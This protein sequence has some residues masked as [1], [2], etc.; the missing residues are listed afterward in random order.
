MLLVK[1]LKA[2]PSDSLGKQLLLKRPLRWDGRYRK[3]AGTECWLGSFVQKSPACRYS[4][5]DLGRGRNI[6]FGLPER[7]RKGF[8]SGL[9][10]VIDSYGTEEPPKRPKPVWSGGCVPGVD[11]G[12]KGLP[13][14]CQIAHHL[15]NVGKRA[16]N[17]VSCLY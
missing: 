6:F 10:I 14:A 8:Q 2:M 5:H 3:V 11:V 1:L 13:Q 12:V 7:E 16:A 17:M 15:T 9:E 4:P